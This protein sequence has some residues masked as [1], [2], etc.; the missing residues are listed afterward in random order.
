MTKH[1]FL[2][3]LF[4]LVGSIYSIFNGGLSNMTI[5]HK[6]GLILVLLI[7]STILIFSILEYIK[8]KSE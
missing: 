6:L 4:L 8:K 3:Y 7:I 5:Y 2:L 1:R